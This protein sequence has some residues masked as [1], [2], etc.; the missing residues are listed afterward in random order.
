MWTVTLIFSSGP[1]YMTTLPAIS[2]QDA[3][4]RAKFDAAQMGWFGK[5][6]KAVARAA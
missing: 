6:K 4:Q 1:E 5:V 3:I 2:E